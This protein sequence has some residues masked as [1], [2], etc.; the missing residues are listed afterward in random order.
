MKKD[1]QKLVA[2]MEGSAATEI[3]VKPQRQLRRRRLQLLLFVVTFSFCIL[4]T[5]GA[6]ISDI[7]GSF[8]QQ[9]CQQLTF[10]LFRDCSNNIGR[11]L[12]N[13][14]LNA[15]CCRLA[16]QANDAY[17]Y[18]DTT[19]LDAAQVVGVTLTSIEASLVLFCGVKTQELNI[20]N[21]SGCATV[22]A[23]LT[24]GPKKKNS[25]TGWGF[26]VVF[27][28][29]GLVALVLV[30]LIIFCCCWKRGA[31]SYPGAEKK[32]LFKGFGNRRDSNGSGSLDFGY[33]TPG[34]GVQIVVQGGPTNFTYEQL[35]D[36]TIA[37]HDKVKL[38]EGAFGGVYRGVLSDG[39]Q[40]AIKR[41]SDESH[42]GKKEFWNE[43]LIISRLQHRNLVRLRGWC[44]EGE[45]K[46]LVYEYMSGG[47]LDKVIFAKE[48][49]ISPGLSWSI[50]CNI[51]MGV[52]NA[53]QYLHEGYDEQVLHR[54]VKC[55]NILLDEQFNARLG[56]F[57]LARLIGH[58]MTHVTTGPAG[59][60]GY[61]PP[62]SVYLW[63][64]TAKWDVY[65]F[66]VVALEVA[67]GRQ[68]IDT[69]RKGTEQ[70][71]LVFA[72]S[73]HQQ[74]RLLELAD[75]RLQGMF[76][77]D[78]IVRLI[79]VGLMCTLVAP[80]D[81]PTMRAVV[82]MLAGDPSTPVMSPRGIIST[83]KGVGGSLGM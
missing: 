32:T 56:D 36:A 2:C 61:L 31:E 13:L 35:S 63:Q 17:C 80:S 40:V 70:S 54:D 42:Q 59:T 72:S 24:T 77:A 74:N 6:N 60:N 37:F 41:L 39:S 52:A 27:I 79:A 21:I 50:R 78:E 66:G 43:A 38:G 67:S 44:S 23:P 18:C 22:P 19:L 68:A 12:T 53:L 47:S 5:S 26:I 1:M 30:A 10:A 8:N 75:P 55:S 45:H 58:D 14:T 16:K 57:G 20:L 62:E 73:L 29:A 81:R 9:Q 48:G 34:D 25:D 76:P 65:S 11:P 7:L 28:V 4:S 3:F 46:L 82:Q 64:P 69:S 49:D 51:I 71:L 15:E 33:P 83:P